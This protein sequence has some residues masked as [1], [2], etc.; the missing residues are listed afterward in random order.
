MANLIGIAGMAARWGITPR[1]V[2]Q[3]S[4]LDDFP[5]PVPVEGEDASGVWNTEQVEQW[6]AERVARFP[7]R[8]PTT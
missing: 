5:E 2:R 7:D 1:R 6:R 8:R 3:L 4:E